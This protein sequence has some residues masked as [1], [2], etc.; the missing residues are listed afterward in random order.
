MTRRA[1]LSAAVAIVL[2]SAAACG[3]G[4][5]Q[6]STATRETE[7]STTAPASTTPPS[8]TPP[9]G[10][11][12]FEAVPC[13]FQNTT[14][15]QAACGDLSV[16]EDRSDTDSPT[17]T[18][19]VAVFKALTSSPAPDPIVYLDGGP[20]VAT[21]EFVSFG[22]DDVFLP[23][24][25]DRD[26]VFFDQRG[27]GLSEPSLACP[28]VVEV[29]K[30]ILDVGPTVDEAVDRE[31]EAW[32][33]CRDRLLA[34]G[35]DLATYNS[36]ASAADVADLQRAL[37]YESWNLLGG[38]YGSRLALTVMRDAPDGLRAAIL[39]SV[40]PPHRS[41][42]EEAPASFDR[43][44]DLLFESCA[45]D[46]V[47][48]VEHPELRE[49]LFALVDRLDADPVEVSILDVFDGTTLDVSL[50]GTALISLV[51][52]GLHSPDDIAVIPRM[53]DEI[54]FGD[55]TIVSELGS[56]LLALLGIGSGG[57]ASSV[58]CHEEVPFST[59]EGYAAAIEPFP[60]F[61]EF[62]A[63]RLDV[64]PAVFELC[65]LWPAGFGGDIE[66]EPVTSDLPALVLAGQFD[67]AT[68][69]SWGRS[70]TETLTN[71]Y[72]FE[73]P[74]MGHGASLHEC[75][76]SMAVEFLQNPTT[77]PDSSCIAD[78][79]TIAFAA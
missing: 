16:P 71:S 6:E 33:A 65:E 59:P 29:T 37:G 53:I 2:V 55:D 8:T 43:A 22:F 14:G 18:L 68:P 23:Y 19:H 72:F 56:N 61:S 42:I 26:V 24:L 45:D 34:E 74:A 58:Q 35:V 25:Q 9:P 62:F 67:P 38:S 70:A 5:E 77:E 10:P 40:Y 54:E 32:E 17:I 47:C 76:Q 79:P 52:W 78:M 73:F 1:S 60:E 57:M 48:A 69:P 64:G 44:L 7:A 20:G 27:V 39:D 15:F 36:A 30:E 4:S 51:G 28:E 11:S 49:R 75:P 31:L 41:L 3:S 66:N 50:D 13:R 46:G 21:L 63:G 12:A